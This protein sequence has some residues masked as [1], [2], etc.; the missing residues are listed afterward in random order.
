M[1]LKKSTARRF[2][3]SGAAVALAVSGVIVSATAPANAAPS[4]GGTLY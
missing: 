1:S 3:A 4:K 2:L